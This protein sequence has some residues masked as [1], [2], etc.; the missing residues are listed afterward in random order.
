MNNSKNFLLISLFFLGFLLYVEWQKD[1]AQPQSQAQGET[2]SIG[3]TAALNSGVNVPEDVPSPTTPISD[4]DVPS[5]EPLEPSNT[6]KAPAL[7]KDAWIGDTERVETNDLILEFSRTGGTLVY[8]ELKKY[9]VEKG[10]TENIKLLQYHTQPYFAKNGL[11]GQPHNFAHN[12]LFDLSENPGRI[13]EGR[14]QIVFTSQQP[15]GTLVKSYT[16]SADGYTIEVQQR[17]QNNTDQ[18]WTV[19]EYHQIERSNPWASSQGSF[20]D[21][22][23]MSFK[24]AGFYDANEGYER[25]DFEDIRGSG[26]GSFAGAQSGWIAMVQHYFM[27]AAIPGKDNVRIETLY[28]AEKTTPYMVRYTAPAKSLPAHTERTFTSTLYIGPKLQDDLPQVAKGLELTVDYGMFT[29]I[30]KPLFWLLEKIHAL[31]GNWG[32]AIVLLTVLIKA[33]FFKLSESQYRS[34]ARMRKLQPRLT[35][36]K[37]RYKD[38]RQKF[39]EE[40]MKLYQKEKVNPLGGCLPLLVQIPVFIAL[41]W[42]LLESVELRQAPF[43]LWLQDLSS[44]DPYYILPAINAAAMYMTQML[45]PHPGMDPMQQKIMKFLPIAFSVLFAFFQSGLVLYWAV[46]SVLSLAQQWVITKRIENQE[47]PA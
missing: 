16:L 28:K 19:A 1:Y 34:M 39:N 21:S 9:P 22:G 36:L 45:T 32:W 11:A 42:V 26:G 38:D 31:V 12:L 2:V 17:L 43:I 15:H 24:G 41:Y 3:D 8:A 5:I 30:A 35:T 29:V 25:V 6:S 14:A 40:M 18:P 10:A 13:T 20:N 46:N 27:T 7:Q 47:K 23:R 37:E 33:L 44:P 4:G